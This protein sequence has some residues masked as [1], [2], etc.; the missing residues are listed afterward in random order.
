L[1]REREKI[2]LHRRGASALG[3][4]QLAIA[5][6]GLQAMPAGWSLGKAPR[7][8]LHKAGRWSDKQWAP[9]GARCHLR[10]RDPSL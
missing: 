6:L 7:P 5:P 3:D 10:G 2:I 9:A 4:A 8:K 1:E